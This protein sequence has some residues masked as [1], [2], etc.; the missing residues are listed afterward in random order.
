MPFL[1]ISSVALTMCPTGV[2]FPPS[3]P[4]APTGSHKASRVEGNIQGRPHGTKAK[5][6]RPTWCH[7]TPALARK[8][9][10]QF[11]EAC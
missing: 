2:C 1:L 6:K 4:S 9:A 7:A 8:E 10:I 3:S 5:W 11:K